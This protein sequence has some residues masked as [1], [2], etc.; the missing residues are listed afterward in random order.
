MLI[1]QTDIGKDAEKLEQI[2]EAVT[3]CNQ[4]GHCLHFPKEK[5]LQ[6]LNVISFYRQLLHFSPIVSSC[7]LMNW[8][9]S[10]FSRQWPEGW[11]EYFKLI[12]LGRKITF[13][14][15]FDFAIIGK[16]NLLCNKLTKICKTTCVWFF[17]SGG[18]NMML[19][20]PSI[21]IET[22]MGSRNKL[23]HKKLH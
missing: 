7:S 5:V 17:F 8:T 3:Q 6:F 23:Q 4:L 12:A 15:H 20:K 16:L 10:T 2:R 11:I 19:L 13:L 18:L 22:V 14:V 21:K 9:R 1:W